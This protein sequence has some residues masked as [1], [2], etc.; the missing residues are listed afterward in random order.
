MDGT[1]S[2]I[3]VEQLREM[4]DLVCPCTD[5]YLYLYDLKN[6]YY[7]ISPHAMER[8]CI[9]NYEFH[10]VSKNHEKFVYPEDLEMLQNDL[11]MMV[12][13]E[14]NFHNLQYRWLG[15]DKS[16]V[17]INCRGRLIYDEWGNP[18]IMLGC[19]NEIGKK[20]KADNNSGLLV[21]SSLR[22]HIQTMEESAIRGF[23]LRIG[24]DDFKEINEN[25]GIEYGDMI[26]KETAECISSVILPGQHLYRIVSDEYMI[27]DFLGGSVEDA[28]AL[29]KKIAQ[30]VDDF[31]E[32]N[33]YEVVYT[34]SGGV[35]GLT[36]LKDCSYLNVMK[37]SEFALS[38]AKRNGKNRCC[39]YNQEDYSKFLYKR[40]L[41][42]ELRHAVHDDF[43]GFDTHFQP[44]V[45]PSNNHLIGAETLL[46]FHSKEMGMIS[47]VEFIP[48]LE[49][50]GLIIPVGKWVLHR[51]FAVCQ[52]WKK[53]I[54]E[55]KISVNLSYIQI[56][57]S[58][59]LTEILT[60]MREYGLK[61]ENVIVELT[62][63]G[64]LES[65]YR[66]IELWNQLRRYGINL[67]IDDFGTGYSNFH[68]LYELS[69]N[70]IKIDRS[71]T[72]KALHSEYEYNLLSHIVDMA[73]GINLKLC[74]EGI[75]TGDELSNINRLKPD[76]I[77]GYYYGKP[78][79]YQDFSD[80]YIEEYKNA[81]EIC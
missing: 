81:K 21:E 26:L 79:T 25:F 17:W 52:E 7:Y 28:Y 56:M 30:A 71:F 5:D 65:N 64:F 45:N 16:P 43:E 9:P 57:K 12:K 31:I 44:I 54:P 62:E 67:A 50:T 61:P 18:S 77:Q 76:Y 27:I 22:M 68:Y 41:I 75:E 36:S 33:R 53:Y 80:S 47:P 34:I 42:H 1:I 13:G 73:R 69:P 60:S 20:Q 78:C 49:E 14:K 38:E 23:M 35:L 48:L 2:N 55:F 58:P 32:R 74:I 39:I 6:D 66:C 72:N 70:I 59:I 29:Y 63:S 4:I 19:I 10:D 11:D 51:A 24:I 37:L 8:F 46:R 15:V 3:T 40:K